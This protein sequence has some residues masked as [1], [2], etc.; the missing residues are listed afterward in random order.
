MTILITETAYK[1]NYTPFLCFY[2]ID[3]IV[4]MR[5]DKKLY[6]KLYAVFPLIPIQK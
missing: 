3:K 5:K 1:T 2:I 4:S 6:P